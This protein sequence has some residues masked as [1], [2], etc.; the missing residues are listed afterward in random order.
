VPLPP[1]DTA[2]LK[3]RLYD[4]FKVEVPLVTWQDKPFIRVS[5]QAYNSSADVDRLLAGLA[6]L[7]DT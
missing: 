6:R 7:L 5:I 4:E 3:T 1:C 2:V